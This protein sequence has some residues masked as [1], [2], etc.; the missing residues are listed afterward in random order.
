MPQRKVKRRRLKQYATGDMNKRILIHTRSIGSP[1]FNSA[2][3]AE[4]YD[5]GLP[6]WSS[7]NTLDPNS[8]VFFDGV[9][10][11][12]KEKP[13]HLFVIRYRNWITAENVIRWR[14]ELYKIVGIQDPDERHEWLELYS[15]ILGDE[16][17]EANQ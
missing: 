1:D 15:K 11:D 3:F 8:K 16:D 7:V 17:L 12:S 6:C 14:K 2:N 10:I 5:S 13:T 4:L 9:D